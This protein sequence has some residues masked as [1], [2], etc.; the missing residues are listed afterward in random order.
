MTASY[1]QYKTLSRQLAAAV[2][3]E[4]EHEVADE[5]ERPP[6]TPRNGWFK[7]KK[8]RAFLGLLCVL[9]AV[10]GSVQAVRHYS[11]E[12]QQ[13]PPAKSVGQSVSLW[14]WDR[15][16]YC[17]SH[18]GL[19]H[20]TQPKCCSKACGALCG[21]TNCDTGDGGASA[22]CYSAITPVAPCSATKNAPCVIPTEATEGPTFTMFG[23][24]SFTTEAVEGAVTAGSKAALAIYFE[25][26]DANVKVTTTT[27]RRLQSVITGPTMW[28]VEFQLSVYEKSLSAVQMKANRVF[29]DHTAIQQDLQNMLKSSVSL[30]SFS[31]PKATTT[32]APPA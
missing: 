19:V 31:S 2:V 5:F 29:A 1:K 7:N 10:A 26:P 24:M 4:E 3:D 16:A 13:Q 20:P 28:S 15:A 18:L 12:A 21:A 30:I 27:S 8:T 9:A 32:A 6:D 23:A 22:C 25:I 11:A 17:T 14:A